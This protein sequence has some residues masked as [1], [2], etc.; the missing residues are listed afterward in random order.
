MRRPLSGIALIALLAVT[1]TACDDDDSPTTPTTPTTTEVTETYTGTLQRN[2]GLTFTFRNNVAGSLV[3]SLS[4]LDPDTTAAIGLAIGTWNQERFA[5]QL[6]IVNDAAFEGAAVVG[7]TTGTA[8][9]CV[10]IYDSRGEL[11]GPVGFVVTVIH[12]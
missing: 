3:A 8:E 9:L 6:T 2:G 4:S 1:A 11:T 5:C 10:R 12:P 7:T